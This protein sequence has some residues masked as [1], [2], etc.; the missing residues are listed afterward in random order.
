M[1]HMSIA[2]ARPRA[3]AISPMDAPGSIPVPQSSGRSGGPNSFACTTSRVDSPVTPE[4]HA[5]TGL[6]NLLPLHHLGYWPVRCIAI[7]AAPHSVFPMRLPPNSSLSRKLNPESW[8]SRCFG[9]GAYL[10][11]LRRLSRRACSDSNSSSSFFCGC[12][13]VASDS[14]VKLCIG[15]FLRQVVVRDFHGL[16][17]GTQLVQKSMSELGLH[18]VQLGSSRNALCH[19]LH[20]PRNLLILGHPV[21]AQ[22]LPFQFRQRYTLKRRKEFLVLSFFLRL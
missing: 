15:Q 8:N 22:F 16:L 20:Q 19:L 13:K 6:S 3:V 7:S 9:Y 12:F 21:E 5:R 14:F 17:V 2:P 1:G 4:A 18:A 11:S 10:V